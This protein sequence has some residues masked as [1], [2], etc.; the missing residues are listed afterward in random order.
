MDTLRQN[1]IT[2]LLGNLDALVE[3]TIISDTYLKGED[4][5]LLHQAHSGII[6]IIPKVTKDYLDEKTK[7]VD[8]SKDIETLFVDYFKHKKKQEPNERIIQLF[9]EILSIPS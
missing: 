8:L 1:G 3:I 4:N 2:P 5:R 6:N 7:K 9:K